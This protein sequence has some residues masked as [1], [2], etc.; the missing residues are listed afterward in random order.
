KDPE[1]PFG[2]CHPRVSPVEHL[3]QCL[4]DVC[5]ADGA[6]HALCQ[7]LQAYAAACQATGAQ[8]RAWRS[9][10]FC[11]ECSEVAPRSHLS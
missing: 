10:T 11:R 8:I 6:R 3:N 9:A 5:V 2:P 4:H 7:S 1:G